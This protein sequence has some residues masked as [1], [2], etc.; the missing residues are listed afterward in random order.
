MSFCIVGT[1]HAESTGLH[2]CRRAL[3]GAAFHDRRSWWLHKWDTT[4][5]AGSVELPRFA[6]VF[7]VRQYDNENQA[8]RE[9]PHGASLAKFRSVGWAFTL[10][11]GQFRIK[12]NTALRR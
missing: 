1:A 8:G 12:K 5:A 7:R 3:A 6:V 2:A 11:K 9:G 4:A 10:R